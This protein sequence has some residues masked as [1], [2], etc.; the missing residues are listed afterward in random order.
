MNKLYNIS[1]I[2]IF[3]IVLSSPQTVFSLEERLAVVSTFNGEVRV[4]HDGV[5][6]TVTKVGN[7]IMNSSVYNGDT[8]LTMPGSNADMIFDDNT[9]LKVEEDTT[10]TISIRQI[11]EKERA[12]EGFVRNVSGT[13]QEVVRNINVKIGKLW[14]DITP[15]KSVLTEFESP[16][17]V[18]S[19]RGTTL[20]FAFLGGATGIDLIKG[21]LDFI[22]AISNLAIDFNSGDALNISE[23]EPGKTKVD[24]TS[25]E[26]T[27]NTSDGT[28][29]VGDG[30]TLNIEVNPDTG[31]ITVV[32]SEGDVTITRP[33]GTTTPVGAGDN[34]GTTGGDGN[35]GNDNNGNNGN[36]PGNDGNDNDGNN[37]NDPDNDG[38]DD[39]GNDGN[40]P[41]ND[42]NDNNGNVNNEDGGDNP[43]PF[44]GTS[45]SQSNQTQ[46]E[47][48]D[49]TG[50]TATEPES[51]AS[52][53]F[54][55]D[56]VAAPAALSIGT[57]DEFSDNFSN[58]LDNW[59]GANVY[60]DS[61]FGSN[62]SAKSGDTNDKFAV[63][64]FGSDGKLTKTFNFQDSGTRNITFDYNIIVTD[65]DFDPDDLF[66]DNGSFETGNFSGWNV[67]TSSGGAASVV[68]DDTFATD[69]N[70]YARLQ[71][72][73][74]ISQGVSWNA[75]EQVRFDWYFD[76]EDYLP[77][78]DWSVFQ[79]KDE[80]GNIVDTIT[81]AD[82][83]EVGNY[84]DSGWKNYIYTFTSDGTGSIKFGVFNKLDTVLDSLLYVDNV[85]G[86][87][88]FVV[89]LHK[90]DGTTVILPPLLTNLTTTAVR[91]LPADVVSNTSGHQTGWLSVDWTGFVPSGLTI[92]EFHLLYH[93]GDDKDGA[94][95]LDNVVDPLVDIDDETP[96][97]STDYLLA[98][99]RA[100][101]NIDT[102]DT[103][104]PDGIEGDSAS[105]ID[106][107][108]NA[109]V[110][111]DAIRES[112]I[113]VKNFMEGHINDFGNAINYNEIKAQ[114]D[115]LL[116]KVDA[117]INNGGGISAS[118]RNE[119]ATVL[120][121][122]CKENSVI[123]CHHN[124]DEE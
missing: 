30:A 115:T 61:S 67:T 29:T 49:N 103:E 54:G 119:I 87:E 47:S 1:I 101:G 33:D 62:I 11:T 15:S 116:A 26:I 35:D 52:T 107:D 102:D 117:S 13:R 81:L 100:I 45:Q 66:L 36:D 34:L 79:V 31:A 23:P 96:A 46:Q 65:P 55:S 70:Y 86:H 25:G 68:N 72:D 24:V 42:G 80:S 44:F 43:D 104:N 89:H 17:G 91:G 83:A 40:D 99:A 122:I 98:F 19:V 12:K 16:T 56:E 118:L 20:I 37:D 113:V 121:S 78:N 75:G 48:S 2:L 57:N 50:T 10:L 8:V 39:D 84:G 53:S 77:Y 88:G 59:G 71:S 14:A 22:S 123:F 106:G 69:G 108:S 3:L 5:W 82:V 85:I 114:L 111:L 7:R 92:L 64:H 109:E 97:S 4:Q 63:I 112:L 21:L 74:L 94:V 6:K 51:N 27:L 110:S 28:V 124:H 73:A 105:R 38:N 76:A 90:S 120:D 95:L 41:G 60:V 18:A 93:D 32:S 9:H 58:G